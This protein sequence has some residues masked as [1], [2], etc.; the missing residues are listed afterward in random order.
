MK[1]LIKM[2]PGLSIP[3][4]IAEGELLP[5][6]IIHLQKRAMKLCIRCREKVSPAMVT[7]LELQLKSELNLNEMKLDL[8]YPDAAPEPAAAP[9]EEAEWGELLSQ[10][11]AAAEA[12]PR[13]DAVQQFEQ[14]QA[15]RLKQ[16]TTQ[17]Q[18]AVS[19]KKGP[20][21]V[22]YGKAFKGKPIP[23]A[24]LGQEYGAVIAEGSVFKIDKRETRRGMLIYTVS[25]TDLSFSINC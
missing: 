25:I 8:R 18:T 3:P 14:E 13:E 10:A 19:Q 23:L 12:P 2:L 22:I 11:D 9:T 20:G 1:D 16:Y 21:S 15:D 4:A 24:E 6:S 5:E 7:Q 17:A